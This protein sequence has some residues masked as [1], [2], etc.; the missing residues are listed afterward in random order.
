M[1]GFSPKWLAFSCCMV[2][3]EVRALVEGAES[4]DLFKKLQRHMQRH[5]NQLAIEV[6]ESARQIA[7]D[8]KLEEVR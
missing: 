1:F 2:N 6:R 4:A 8:C 7:K 3:D 5:W